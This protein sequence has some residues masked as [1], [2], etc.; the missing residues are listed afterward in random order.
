MLIV[1]FNLGRVGDSTAGSFLSTRIIVVA[2]VNVLGLPWLHD[3]INT[4]TVND[5]QQLKTS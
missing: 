1:N 2:D 3:H 4:H 5:C